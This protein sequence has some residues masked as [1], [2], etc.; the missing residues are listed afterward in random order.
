MIPF[1]DLHCHSIF[2]DGTATPREIAL[3][4]KEK[5]FKGVTLTDHDSIEGALLLQPIAEELG[6]SFLMGV[7]FSSSF[8]GESVHILGYSFDPTAPS[9]HNLCERHITRRK[10]RIEKMLAKLKEL[11][12][13][14]DPQLLQERARGTIGRPHIAHLLIE[15]GVVPSIQEA[16]YQYLGEGKKAYVEEESPTTEETLLALHQAGGLAILAHPHLIKPKSLLRKLYTLSFDGIE[17]WYGSFPKHRTLSFLQVA[18]EKK[19]ITT[20]GSDYHGTTKP[21]V[22]YG[23]SFTNE[24]NFIRLQRRS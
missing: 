12:I 10:V 20:G 24:E 5:G 17:T 23:S 1:A 14:I 22:L 2:S 11:G 7:E 9:I 21:H 3:L 13:E 8:R 4:A 19:W 15:K 6:L 18:K 16:F